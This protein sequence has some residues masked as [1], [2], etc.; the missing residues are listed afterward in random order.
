MTRPGAV[1]LGSDFKAL[2][3]VRSL[4]RRGIPSVVVDD[5]PRSAWFSRYVVKRFRWKGAMWGDGFLA[6]LRNL[7]HAEGLANWLLVPLQ[8]EVVELVARNAADL[9]TLYRLT[10]PAWNILRWGHDKRLVN[11]VAD[12]LAISH[13]RTWYP[14][15]AIDLAALEIAFPVIVKPTVSLRLQYALGCKALPANDPDELATQ[16]QRAVDV[17]GAAAI[18][19]QEVIPGDGREQYSLAAF[20]KDGQVVAGMT[21]RRRRQFP[22]DYGLGSSLVEA[23][24]APEVFALGRR[25]L[26]RLLLSGMVEVEFKHDRRDGLYKLLDVNVRPW[27]WHSLCIACGLD[28][29]Y[30]AYC[31][32]FGLPLPTS[33]PRYGLVWRRWITDVPAGLQEVTHGVTSPAEYVRSLLIRSAAPSVFDLSDPL[34]VVGDVVSVLARSLRG[35][36]RGRAAI[37]VEQPELSPSEA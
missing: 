20:C 3:V 12:A 23:V 6:F 25:L 30:I 14:D 29:P 4:G 22:F 7:A 2:G 1:V 17:V 5:V 28:F 37:P 27:G 8:D 35:A 33:T 24:E 34:P 16:Y 13:P 11:S 19:I 9:G 31:D 21:A 10:T 26:A 18:M 36:N 32:A 15:S